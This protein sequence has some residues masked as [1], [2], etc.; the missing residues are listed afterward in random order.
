MAINWG[1]WK[2]GGGNG[3]RVGMEVTWSA[4]NSGSANVTA[5]VDFWTENQY[6]YSDGQSLNISNNLG[7]NHSYT[8]NS[9]GSP[10]KRTTR[11]YTY[12][13]S[14]WGSSPGSVTFGATVE[15]TYNSIS[16]SVSVAYGIPARP[17]GPPSVTSAS[18]SAGVR[19]A[20]ISWSGS[21]DPGIYQYNV[22]RNNDG[23]QL[24]YASSGT[25]TTDTALGNGQTV[26]YIVYAYNA[27]GNGYAF[28]NTVT[29]P[30]VPGA[31]GV[32]STPNNGFIS[33]SYSAPASDGGTGITSYQYS[34]NGGAWT[35]TPSN[36]FNISGAN[37]TAITVAVRAVN[38]AGEGGSTSTTNTPRT[39]P[40]QPTSFAGNN[41]TFGQLALSWA[42]PSSNGGAAITTY[43]LFNGATLLQ[44]S[45]ST[46]YTHTGLLPYTDYSYTVVATNVA[47]DSP[48]ASLTVKTMGGIAKVWNGT[49]YFTTLPK[50]WNGTTWADAQARMWN[51][52]EWKHG[53]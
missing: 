14:T 12:T 16:P 10:V 43:K 30:N 34:A 35:T 53:I 31:P 52:T 45:L 44:N 18:A 27:A 36:P 40:T 7:S 51:G 28:T 9:G 20:S 26:Y 47:G 15:G 3:M 48:V 42:A 46:S 39:V 11:T 32:S 33:V 49:S 4:V 38:A 21:G 5:T 1:A 6:T 41:A 13:Y 29:T 50:V 37:G 8:N 24:I 25:S 23:N 22:Y 2:Y 17:G 19:S